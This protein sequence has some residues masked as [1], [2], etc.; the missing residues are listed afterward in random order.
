MISPGRKPLRRRWTACGRSSWCCRIKWIATP[1]LAVAS[2][3]GVEHIVFLSSGAVV[4]GV[5]QQPDVIAQYHRDVERAIETSGISWTFLR[6]FFPAIN[7]LSFAMQLTGGDVIRAPFANA[8]SAPIHEKDVADVAAAVLAGGHGGLIYE[9]T[10]PQSVT[11]AEQVDILGTALARPLSF[12]ELD[13]APV[14][15]QMAQ[16]MDPAFINA[17]FDLMAA[18]VDKPAP[19]NA[20]VEQLTGHTPRSYA[21]WVDDHIS[22]FA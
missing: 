15:E 18:T 17:L 21:Q 10:G 11:Q 5:D 16:F 19:V 14:R 13:D 22:D 1:L 7:S 9:L 8:A 2:G 4:D 20:N 12:E 3:A 6:L